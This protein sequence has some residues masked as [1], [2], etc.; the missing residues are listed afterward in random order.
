MATKS[1]PSFDPKAFLAKVGEGR[2]IEGYHKDQ[3][4]FSQ[5]IL[6]MRS[7]TSRRSVGFWMKLEALPLIGF[8]TARSSKRYV[9]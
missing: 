1:R 9:R 4:V 6:R 7:S 2:S 3:I 5:E 8:A